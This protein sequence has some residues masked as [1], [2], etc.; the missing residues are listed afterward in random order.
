L[1]SQ[2]A[3]PFHSPW[4][5]SARVQTIAAPV[6]RAAGLALLPRTPSAMES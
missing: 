3:A 1:S 5:L 6:S 2:A 4:P